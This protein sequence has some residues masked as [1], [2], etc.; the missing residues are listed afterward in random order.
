MQP[1]QVRTVRRHRCILPPSKACRT[2]TSLPRPQPGRHHCRHQ[3]GSRGA[4][5]EVLGLVGPKRPGFL[6]TLGQ[7]SLEGLHQLLLRLQGRPTGR[8]RLWCPVG[9]RQVAWRLRERC[10]RPRLAISRASAG[11]PFPRGSSALQTPPSAHTAAWLPA[12]VH[13]V[14]T[15]PHNPRLGHLKNSRKPQALTGGA[16]T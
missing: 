14:S 2:S 15:A 7:H 13:W 16:G 1:V 4:Y 11:S 8:P 6:G 5:I 10:L 3:A 9:H 12:Q